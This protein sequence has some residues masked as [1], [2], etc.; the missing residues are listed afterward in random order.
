MLVLISLL[1]PASGHCFVNIV[2]LISHI[3]Y[4]KCKSSGLQNP[5]QS[6]CIYK[7]EINYLKLQRIF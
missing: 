7:V 6:T 3:T 1:E 2:C 5:E 4:K